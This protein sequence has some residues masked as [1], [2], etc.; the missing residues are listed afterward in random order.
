MTPDQ[1]RLVQESWAQVAPNAG[2]VASLFYDRLFTL[3]PSLRFM[4]AHADM[5]E[6][7]KKLTQMLTVA[8][9]SLD[10]LEQLLPAVD[11]L[12]RRHAGYGVRDE[13]YETVGCA[14]LDTLALG[15]GDA[16]TPT[17]RTAWTEVY[18]ALSGVMQRA[19]AEEATKQRRAAEEEAAKRRHA[20][21][22]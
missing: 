21:A 2:L 3:D 20:A 17:A 19:A 1:K 12:G 6:Q 15:L 5:T 4:F 14:L 11:A 13:H 9:K 10:R 22:A 8:V 7:G 16:F 18:A